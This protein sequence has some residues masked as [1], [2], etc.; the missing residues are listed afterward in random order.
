MSRRRFL[1]FATTALAA[2]MLVLPRRSRAATG[3]RELSFLHTHTGEALS[4]RYA[5]GDD[6]IGPAL[7]RIDWFLRDFRTGDVSP[8]DPQLL[9]QLHTLAAVTRSKTPF[10][11]ISGYRSPLTNA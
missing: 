11:V 9:D 3:A 2:P 5:A 10:Q 6:Y 7:E 1:T 8:I 4:I